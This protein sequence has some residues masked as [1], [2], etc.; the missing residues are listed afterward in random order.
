[1]AIKIPVSAQFDAADVKKQIQIINDQIKILGHT[2]GQAHKVKF[3]PITVKSKDDMNGLLKQMQQLLKVQTELKQRMAATGQGSTNP[4]TADWEKLYPNRGERLIKQRRMLQFLGNE[5]ARDM[6]RPEGAT[7]SGVRPPRPPTP[8]PPPPAGGFGQSPKEDPGR[9]M[10]MGGMGFASFLGNLG[11]QALTKIAGQVIQKIGDSQA[12]SITTDRILRQS[13]TM[14]NFNASRSMLYGGANTLGMRVN[15]FAS[16]AANYQR[17]ADYKGDSYDLARTV[18]SIGQFARGYGLDPQE[19]TSTFAGAQ[20]VGVANNDMQIRKLGML[21]GE[22][23]GKSHA[24][25]SMDKFSAVVGSYITSNARETMTAPNTE[26]YVAALAGLV[27]T[28][29]GTD[30]EGSAAALAQIDAAIKRGGSAGEAGVNFN[31]RTATRN[32]LDA[33]Q[34]L[35]LQSGGAFATAGSTMGAGSDYAKL[36]G[37]SLKGNKTALQMTMEELNSEYQSPSMRIMAISRYMGVNP[38][39]AAKIANLKPAEMGDTSANLQRYGID[40]SKLDMS[41]VPDLV[42]VNSK[43]RNGAM[44]IASGLVSGGKL[45]AEEK[46]S[47][48]DAMK[49]GDDDELKKITSQLVATHGQAETEGSQ[50][51]K[52][53]SEVSNAI[54]KQSD[55]LLAPINIMRMAVV[56]LAGGSEADITEE[57]WEGRLK[58]AEKA[59]LSEIDAKLADAKA[60]NTEAYSSRGNKA[61]Q[62]ATDA[63]ISQ[64]N[65]QRED[66]RGPIKAQVAVQRMRENTNTTDLAKVMNRRVDDKTWARLDKMRP[67]I[68]EAAEKY[69]VDP[70][71]LAAI[72]LQESGARAGTKKNG[73]GATGAFQVTEGANINHEDLSTLRG[74]TMA[75]AAYLANR[76][77]RYGK[78][79]GIAAYNAGSPGNFNNHE[80]QLYLP[81]VENYRQQVVEHDEGIRLHPES[82]EAVGSAVAQQ[83]H[84]KPLKTESHGTPSHVVHHQT[85]GGFNLYNAQVK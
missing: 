59:G 85:K 3:E 22:G 43:G 74:N 69:G 61:D 29:P 6:T 53:I 12:L 16:M 68:N 75:A 73:K 38:L 78:T 10:S 52:S 51:R 24:F 50:T 15:E 32:N 84:S 28:G 81:G 83:V 14:R 21:I 60:R 76:Q 33:L 64:L 35:M 8:P 54:Q 77:K 55:L 47:L 19:A 80:T 11:V 39:M 72:A 37:K 5:F 1:M 9:S 42:K 45:S 57:Y 30:V 27:N 56:K 36:T 40:T 13:G 65:K 20:R 4:L 70:Q 67:L 26:G 82:V 71:T 31:A 34:M 58:D 46:R 17:Q 79:P 48:A 2:V 49:S 66:Y 44:E 25:A 23:V 7:G 62:Q 63:E 18:T 41:T